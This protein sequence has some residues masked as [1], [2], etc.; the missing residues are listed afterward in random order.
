MIILGLAL[1]DTHG[2]S[3]SGPKAASFQCMRWME[4]GVCLRQ[5]T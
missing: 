3:C 4:T 5:V 2:V 1:I